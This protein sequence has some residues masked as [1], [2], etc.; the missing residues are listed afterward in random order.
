VNE[1]VVSIVRV[2]MRLLLGWKLFPVRTLLFELIPTIRMKRGHFVEGS[3][4]REFSS[5]YI[6]RELWPSEVGSRSRRYRKTCVFGKN[7]PCGKI[8]KISFQKDSP[9][10]RSM[11]CVQI[12]WNLADRKSVK[13]FV[14]Y[15]TKK[16]KIGSLSL[17]LMREPRPKS[18]RACG[19]QC[20]HS[21]PNFIQIGSLPAEL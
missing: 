3:F 20:T 2:W 10:R 8:L 9:P 17:S 19:K 18:A 16:T 14:F 15:R 4:S 5:I 7:D 12:S 21:A 1:L 6:V 11:F 13:S